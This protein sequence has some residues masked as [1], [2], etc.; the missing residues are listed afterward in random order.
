MKSLP[1]HLLL[2]ILLLCT[3]VSLAHALNY[4]YFSDTELTRFGDRIMFW[5]GDT[6]DGPIRTN[7][8]FSIM[9][10]PVFDD[11]VISGASDF[12]HGSAYNPQFQPRE[13]IF[14]GPALPLPAQAVWLRTQA[15]AGERFFSGGDSLW[16]RVRLGDHSF[17]LW[18]TPMGVPLLDT[19]QFADVPLPDSAVVFF[20]CHDLNLLGTLSSVLLLGTSGR[21]NLED[22]VLYA[23]ADPLTGIAPA[24]HPEKLLVL[25]EGEIKVMNTAANGRA[26][27]N[28]AGYTQSNP[29]YSSIV[30][31]GI[32]AAL[33]ESFTFSQQNDPDSGYVCPCQPDERG[34]ISLF[35]SILQRQRGYVHRTTR[36]STGYLKKHR[37]DNDLR[38]WD[39]HLFDARENEA[40]PSALSFAGVPGLALTDTLTIANDYVPI[41]LDSLTLA[42]PF[43]ITQ[44]E[45]D[46]AHWSPTLL[47]R[48]EPETDGV[49]HDTLR[50]YIAYYDRWLRVPLTG[51]ATTPEVEGIDAG[52]GYTPSEYAL[53][54]APNPFNARTR[55]AF[56]LP[57]AG[58]TSVRIYDLTGRE[59]ATL[60]S[61]TLEAGNHEA[62]W[63]AAGQANGVYFVRL[64][65]VAGTRTTKLLLLK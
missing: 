18:W 34:T 47:V 53:A 49:Y 45:P 57:H 39:I 62:A 35:G 41:R 51:V 40:V 60:L 48:F 37:Y 12:W 50:C 52:P 14:G 64:T 61:Q 65:S 6:L 30:L 33:G 31:D 27:A 8:M 16:A 10:D 7:E 20:D 19:T 25:A 36:S 24:G 32:Y 56:T 11:F 4:M 59:I 28:G 3:L 42:P 58:L 63:D 21:V 55:I 23:S 2:S 13:V 9:Q 22:N 15:L 46:S 38:F 26:N 5:R 54:A 1:H 17:R 29:A 44:N 43:A